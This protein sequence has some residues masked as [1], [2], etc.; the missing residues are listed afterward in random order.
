[1]RLLQLRELVVDKN[2]AKSIGCEKFFNLLEWKLLWSKTETKKAPN[3]TPSLYWAYYALAKL[4]GWHDS[5]QTGVVGWEAHGKV[6]F[7]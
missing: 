6:G 1:M 3:T 7:H 2:N 4:G 5:K